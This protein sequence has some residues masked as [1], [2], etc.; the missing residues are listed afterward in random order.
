MAES[1][2]PLMCSDFLC[3]STSTGF[4]ALFTYNWDRALGRCLRRPPESVTTARG[5]LRVLVYLFQDGF[6]RAMEIASP[7]TSFWAWVAPL[8]QSGAGSSNAC[9]VFVAMHSE[10]GEHYIPADL[11][12]K[13][14]GFVWGVGGNVVS[15]GRLADLNGATNHNFV[16]EL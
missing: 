16:S 13:T 15:I 12:S 3:S 10:C 9:T 1:L 7:L 11:I 4:V 14:G 8:E 6:G 5:I 2:L